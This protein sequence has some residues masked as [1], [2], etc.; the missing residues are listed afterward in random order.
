M[1]FKVTFKTNVV[2][3]DSIQIIHIEMTLTKQVRWLV[4]GLC[5]YIDF[6]YCSLNVAYVNS[7]MS[8]IYTVCGLFVAFVDLYKLYLKS[9]CDIVSMWL[10]V[11]S[12]LISTLKSQSS[13]SETNFRGGR[14]NEQIFSRMT[15]YRLSSMVLHLQ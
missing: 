6:Y 14:R 8:T 7:L 15:S 5:G 2:D 11:D 9:T 3:V 10:H 4:S 13:L 1:C 12:V